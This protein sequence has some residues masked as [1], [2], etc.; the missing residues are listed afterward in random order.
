MSVAAPLRGGASDFSSVRRRPLAV[1]HSLMSRYHE[2]LTSYRKMN[3]RR[4]IVSQRVLLC[5]VGH[6]RKH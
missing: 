1:E 3:G 4:V 5:G 6:A 2:R